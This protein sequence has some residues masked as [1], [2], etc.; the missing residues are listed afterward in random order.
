[1]KKPIRIILVSLLAVLMAAFVLSCA[2]C[3]AVES[4]KT[5]FE[6]AIPR[7]SA[8]MQK[9]EFVGTAEKAAS[10]G[11]VEIRCED[12]DLGGEDKGSASV[13]FYAN[14]DA[15]TAAAILS[16]KLGDKKYEGAAYLSPKSAVVQF[17]QLLGKDAYGINLAKAKE[18]LKKSVF[19]TDSDTDYALSERMT[20]Q[21]NN[22][23]D[24][25][26]NLSKLEKDGNKLYEKYAKK[27]Y[28]TI[29]D[30]AEYEKEN[31]EVKIFDESDVPCTAVT[32]KLDSKAI[33]KAVQSFWKDAKSDSELKKYISD[34][35]ITLNIGF[36]DV[37]DLYDKID[38]EVE[39]LV[40]D[41]EDSDLTVTVRYYLN[42][43]SGAIMKAELIIRDDNGN[44]TTYA[45]ELG[46]EFKTFEGLKVT[47]KR[48]GSDAMYVWLKVT[49]NSKDEF[50]CVLD[51]KN[52]GSMPEF[53]LKYTKSDGSVKITF[54][55]GRT[56]YTVKLTYKKSGST[57]TVTL[58]S[59]SVDGE[60][61]ELPG[62]F[63]VI[64]NTKAKA[65]S[66]PSKYTDILTMKEED[67]EDFIEDV[68]KNAEDI[69]K[70]FGS[71]AEEPEFD[72]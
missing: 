17:E 11:S 61:V 68:Q 7:T 60:K 34:N 36:E 8:K 25:I 53:S 16:A 50:K 43:S 64:V 2:S 46:K 59:V 1:M 65:P 30:N 6:K 27:L 38:D 15:K 62:K 47:V 21:V 3:T 26:N 32:V 42:K 12:L 51:S 54:D 69:E 41:L 4:P 10:G 23:I 48:D 56:E 44:K 55:D 29:A 57:H 18:N 20:E 39:D 19:D 70:E 35:I 58:D 33:S 49:E 5:L 52:A 24:K 37:G 66:A 9:L 63:S 13:V 14:A 40:D 72:F 28:K 71:G 31:T 67:F 22:A 45:V